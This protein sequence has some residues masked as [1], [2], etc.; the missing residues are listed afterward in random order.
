MTSLHIKNPTSLLL[1][2]GLATIFLYAAIS[3]FLVPEEWVG[4]F[5]QVLRDIVPADILLPIF[6]IYELLLAG[7]L[8]SGLYVQY[9]ALLSAATLAGIVVSN[10]QLFAITFRDI[11]LIFASIALFFN[12]RD[13]K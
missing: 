10:F 3:S 11:A 6:S 12:E 2:F 13:K 8:L 7:W 9:A 5:P 1:R 4:Y